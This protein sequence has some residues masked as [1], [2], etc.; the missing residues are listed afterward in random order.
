MEYKLLWSED[1]DKAGGFKESFKTKEEFI[2][3]V[4][5]EFK[6][7]GNGECEVENVRIE[8]CISTEKGLPGDT[9]VPLSATDVIIENYYSA[10]VIIID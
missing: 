10:D 6:S 3:Q 9:L 2:D 1:N 8:A 5:E 4:K 7:F